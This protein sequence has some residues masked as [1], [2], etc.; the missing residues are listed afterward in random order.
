VL[1]VPLLTC[2]HRW[3]AGEGAGSSGATGTMPRA[4][5]TRTTAADISSGDSDSWVTTLQ[6]QCG[7]LQGNMSLRGRGKGKGN[8]QQLLFVGSLSHQVQAQGGQSPPRPTHTAHQPAS[9]PLLAHLQVAVKWL[10][11]P[12]GDPSGVCTGHRNPQDSG[13]SLRTVVVRSSAK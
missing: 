10:S 1:P 6:Q 5:S 3:V 8:G 7:E 11:R 9:P 12:Q 13:S 2:M 4:P